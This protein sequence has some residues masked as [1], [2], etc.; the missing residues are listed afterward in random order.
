MNKA[1]ILILFL[2]LLKLFSQKKNKDDD[3][4]EPIYISKEAYEEGKRIRK[5]DEPVYTTMKSRD[6][7]RKS[8]E[9]GECIYCS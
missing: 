9:S 5:N 2:S 8:L 3:D 7:A 1:L 4:Y 6:E